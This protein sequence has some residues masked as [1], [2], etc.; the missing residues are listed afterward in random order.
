M[1]FILYQHLIIFVGNDFKPE[2]IKYYR[3]S[4]LLAAY[5]G[6]KLGDFIF[7]T[8]EK[9]KGKWIDQK[10][11]E[12]E[13]LDCVDR[14]LI[15][16]I[17]SLCKLPNGCIAGDEHFAN[18]T[19][20]S[21]SNTNKRINRL[22]NLGYI[23]TFIHTKNK[24][25]IGRTITIKTKEKSDLVF[26]NVDD[27]ISPVKDL[28]FQNV[29]DSISPVNINN[30]ITNSDIIIQERIQYTGAINSNSNN[31][32]NQILKNQYEELSFEIGSKSSLGENVFIYADS[33]NIEMYKENTS[34]D[35]FEL[36]F[37]LLKKLIEIQ[38]K[39]YGK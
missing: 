5:N 20:Q 14:F 3:S 19:R 7:M 31:S 12:D 26:Q 34:S 4:F 28:V 17:F 24:K 32:L 36:I 27:S 2:C 38:G 29:D 37:P 35:E 18:L 6:E 39:L 15:S 10:F 16:E 22:K 23:N 9:K 25:I 11:I 8:N 21:I 13:N 30:T 33:R 1:I